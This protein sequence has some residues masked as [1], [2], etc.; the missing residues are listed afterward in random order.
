VPAEIHKK[1]LILK[2]MRNQLSGV[3][4][5]ECV[6]RDLAVSLRLS[7]GAGLA[8]GVTTAVSPAAAY[9]S[10]IVALTVPYVGEAYAPLLEPSSRA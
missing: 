5:S 1:C 8:P 9:K 4:V 2:M 3:P 10:M 7:S 6:S